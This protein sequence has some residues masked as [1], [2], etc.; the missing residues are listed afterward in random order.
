[1]Q[2]EEATLER[3][4]NPTPSCTTID[5]SSAHILE[6]RGFKPGTKRDTVEMFIENK[7]G[8][9]EL[10]SCDYD[11]NT[12]VAVV[13]FKNDQGITVMCSNVSTIAFHLF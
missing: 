6:I 11:T 9:S 13:A 3:G 12:G 10:Q 4:R 8:E 1:M 2:V 5:M 7:S